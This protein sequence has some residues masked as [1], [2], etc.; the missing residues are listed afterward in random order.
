MAGE[1]ARREYH[2]RAD[3]G[4]S[5]WRF[6]D[7]R[8]ADDP[9]RS[10]GRWVR[11]GREESGEV[12]NELRS[13]LFQPT[14]RTTA[15][16]VQAESQ[17]RPLAGAVPLAAAL[18]PD[19]LSTAEDHTTVSVRQM[20]GCRR[21]RRAVGTKGEGREE[22][23]GSRVDWLIFR[24]LVPSSLWAKARDERYSVHLVNR[25]LAVVSVLLWC[26]RAARPRLRY[27]TADACL[28]PTST[29]ARLMSAAGAGAP[30][31][32]LR[33]FPAVL[34]RPISPS[35]IDSAVEVLTATRLA[36]RES[37]WVQPALGRL[38]NVP[39][40]VG[41][42]SRSARGSTSSTDASPEAVPS[43]TSGTSREDREAA[44]GDDGDWLTDPRLSSRF[45]LSVAVSTIAPFRIV[46]LN[47]LSRPVG[48]RC[49][50][51]DTR[52]I[53][54]AYVDSSDESNRW[55]PERKRLGELLPDGLDQGGGAVWLAVDQVV[56]RADLQ[57]V[58]PAHPRSA[59]SQS[60]GDDATHGILC[61]LR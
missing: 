5:S 46:V 42:P 58:A 51:V 12:N 3:F 11:E 18:R 45:P 55:E 25:P 4:F 15:A 27:S 37:V 28:W 52:P 50:G 1:R 6:S 29:G 35:P 23:C 39:P 19:N 60:T 32:L 7:F 14:R 54:N 13:P 26:E 59:S 41:R 10:N 22:E 48:S 38:P 33:S 40:S 16:A 61:E 47:S 49:T 56:Q 30:P 43:N 2:S 8:S 21:R 57:S 34:P 20:S 31:P 9:G 53:S 44:I 36:S 24:S 17:L